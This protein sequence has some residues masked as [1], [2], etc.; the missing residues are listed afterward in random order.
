MTGV[1]PPDSTGERARPH[2]QPEATS[3]VDLSEQ[4]R[5]RAEAPIM[6]KAHGG[7]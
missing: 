2:I 3:R 7:G 5:Q 6:P 1:G 4:C